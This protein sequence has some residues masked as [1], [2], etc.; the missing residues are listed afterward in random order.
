MTGTSIC[1]P[2]LERQSDQMPLCVEKQCI[3]VSAVKGYKQWIVEDVGHKP[4][5]LFVK[6]QCTGNATQPF[7]SVESESIERL[8]PCAMI[9]FPFVLTQLSEL[10]IALLGIVINGIMLQTVS[11]KPFAA[12]AVASTNDPMI[13]YAYLRSNQLVIVHLRQ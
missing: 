13:C 8:G 11:Q 9:P 6:C 4:M 3:R 12:F 5:L 10:S 2:L 1:L 7:T